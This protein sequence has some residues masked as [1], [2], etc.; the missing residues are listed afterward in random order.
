ML[1][2]RRKVL[3]VLWKQLPWKPTQSPWVSPAVRLATK[4]LIGVDIK[5]VG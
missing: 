4:I 2:G 1:I 3:A 5:D